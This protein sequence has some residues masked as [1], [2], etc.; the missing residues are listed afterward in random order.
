M[1]IVLEY[2]VYIDV[3][4]F[5]AFALDRVGQ[6][7]YVCRRSRTRAAVHKSASDV[8]FVM[9]LRCSFGCEVVASMNF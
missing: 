4:V 7:A 3:C 8:F 5:G 9:S 1:A 2:N 6:C